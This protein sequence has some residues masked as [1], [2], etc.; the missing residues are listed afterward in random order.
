M[1]LIIVTI[2]AI[3]SKWNITPE[4]FDKATYCSTNGQGFYIVESQT[5][6]AEYHVKYNRQFG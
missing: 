5:T 4:Q 6:D 2:A 3:C 1:T